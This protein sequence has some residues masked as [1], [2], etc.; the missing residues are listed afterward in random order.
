ML[1]QHATL[2]AAA[3]EE[4][5]DVTTMLQMQLRTQLLQQMEQEPTHMLQLAGLQF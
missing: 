1:S 2:S 4:D 5:A 3:E